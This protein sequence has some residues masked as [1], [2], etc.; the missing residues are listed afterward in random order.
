M[1]SYIIDDDHVSVFLTEQALR[2]EGVPKV[3]T[4]LSPEEALDRLKQ[5][6]P[7]KLP[8]FVLLDLN[9]PAMSG[10]ELLDKLEPYEEEILNN[11]RVYILTSS[12]DHG[13][14]A[15]SS[16]YSLVHGFI[17]KPL[18]REDVQTILAQIEDNKQSL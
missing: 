6:I 1:H 2:V 10:W 16:D 12:L 15:K 11:T 3:T 14:S 7:D 8:D 13:D 17:H 4:F 18:D 9:M 5:E